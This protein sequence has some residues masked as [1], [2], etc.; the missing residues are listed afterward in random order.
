[1]ATGASRNWNG[2]ISGRGS[3][4]VMIKLNKP[5][6]FSDF[7]RPICLPPR[8]LAP[9]ELIHCHT[10]GWAK[11]REFLERIEVSVIQMDLCAN[12]SITSV[13]GVCTESVYQQNDCN[14]F[15]QQLLSIQ[16]A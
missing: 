10:L 13:N 9:Q 7:I 5:V 14:L 2:Q 3:T 15:Y 12:I 6:I 8:S 16:N 11:N 4:V 1:M